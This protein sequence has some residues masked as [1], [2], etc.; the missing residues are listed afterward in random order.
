M[1][2]EEFGTVK[3]GDKRVDIEVPESCGILKDEIQNKL[4]NV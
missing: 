4:Q 1:F 3:E 2:A